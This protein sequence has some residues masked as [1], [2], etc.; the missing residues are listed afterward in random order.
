MQI[1]ETLRI[2]EIRIDQYDQVLNYGFFLIL[3]RKAL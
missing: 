2:N 1:V 3:G